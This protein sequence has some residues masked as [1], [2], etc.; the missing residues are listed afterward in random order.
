MNPDAHRLVGR[1]ILKELRQNYS[2]SINERQ[3]LLGC[4]APD[5]MPQYK[6]VRH[7]QGES[8]DFVVGEIL[9][10]LRDLKKTNGIHPLQSFYLDKVSFRLGVIAH[11]LTDYVTKP[12][13]MRQQFLKFG[14][15]KEHIVYET[16]LSAFAKQEWD[17]QSASLDALSPMGHGENDMAGF[18]EKYINAI[19]EDY[20]K[21]EGNYQRDLSYALAINNGILQEVL[22]RVPDPIP[23]GAPVAQS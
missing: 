12:H 6:M 10:V 2:F 4:V 9:K 3:F 1:S 5:F 13:A 14:D 17:G 20:K 11:Y 15:M 8:M 16:G 19:V 21:E 23:M 7:Y 22:V 18:F